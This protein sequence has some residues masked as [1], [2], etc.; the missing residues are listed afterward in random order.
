MRIVY[1]APGFPPDIGGIETL[2]GQLL[3]ALR[4]RG[5]DFLVIAG[6]PSAIRS[7]AA[8]IPDVEVQRFPFTSALLARDLGRVAALRS[9]ARRVEQRF[10]PD[11]VHLNFGGPDA[12]FHLHE[13]RTPTL[14]TLHAP[15]PETAD[16][17]EPMT[18]R[19]ARSVS[20][21]SAVSQAVLDDMLSA[22]PDIADRSGVLYNGV[23]AA[24]R[25][26]APLPFAPPRILCLGRV[27]PE[28][29]FDVAIDALPQ[30]RARHPSARLTIGGDGH[31]LD[32]LRSRAL[33]RGVADAVDF[34]GAVA[35]EE[36]PALIETATVVAIPSRW[37]EPFCLVAVEAAQTGRP[38]VASG[39]AGLRETVSDGETGVLVPV[40]DAAA[41]GTTLADLLDDPARATRLGE[42]GRSRA[43]RMFGIEA[44]ANAHD[45]L[46]RRLAPDAST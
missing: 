2:A 36:V 16:D 10:E 41:L 27:S 46:Y 6:G 21:T 9:A 24:D 25:P 37:R 11:L 39:I 20:W 40:E 44:C 34:A 8:A 12:F 4:D 28:K 45:D 17:S 19:L 15:I 35:R 7:A 5:H 26:P 1:R 3:P 31:A 22:A 13:R 43:Q 23:V 30:V 38:V 18:V 29:G 14:L 32:S 33:A 42:A